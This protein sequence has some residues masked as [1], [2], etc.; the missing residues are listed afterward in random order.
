MIRRSVLMPLGA[1]LVGLGLV[2]VGASNAHAGMLPTLFSISPN[3]GSY[4]YQYSV[5]VPS[6]ETVKAG[7]S[8]ILYDFGGYVP[9]T[10]GI[11]GAVGNWTVSV[12]NTT[13]P[14]RA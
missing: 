11:S 8:F 9:G 12:A 3:S 13:T 2:G 7:D 1:V 6:N 10:V 5:F 14:R 4:Q